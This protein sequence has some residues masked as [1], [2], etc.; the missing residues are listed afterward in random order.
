MPVDVDALGQ[1][2]ATRVARKAVQ[3]R[4]R[5]FVVVEAGEDLI[6]GVVDVAHQHQGRPA[7]FQPV[8]MRSVHL[9]HLPVIMTPLSPLS[10]FVPLAPFLPISAYY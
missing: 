2:V 1:A 10:M 6:R 7:A 3:R 4:Q 8:V 5:A 9:L